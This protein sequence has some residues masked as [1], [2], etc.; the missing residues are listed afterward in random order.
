MFPVLSAAQ[1]DVARR[2]ASGPSRRFE[3]GAVMVE[4]GELAAPIWLVLAGSIVASWRDGLGHET[5]IGIEGPGQFSGEVSQLGGHTSLVVGRAG[6]EGC[7]AIPFD[8]AHLRA[9]VI[10][11]ADIGEIVMRAFILRRVGLIET[12][13]SGSILIGHADMPDV[14]RLQGF[15]TRNG[16]PVTVLD[17]TSDRRSA[18]LDRAAGHSRG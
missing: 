15:L 13:R 17:A 14:V 10:G 3:P 12:D 7:T 4:V 9:L 18:C 1:I 5:E 6:P 16:Y 2:F 8:P 11:S